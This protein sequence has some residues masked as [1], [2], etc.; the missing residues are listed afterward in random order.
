MGAGE[1]EQVFSIVPAWQCKGSR[2]EAAQKQ[3]TPAQKT[4]TSSKNFKQKLQAKIKSIFAEVFLK[5]RRGP[6]TQGIVL[7]LERPEDHLLLPKI[8][9]S[10]PGPHLVHKRH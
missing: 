10:G 1:L 4:Q 9:P 2:K 3:L 8:A 5:V 6:V 7:E